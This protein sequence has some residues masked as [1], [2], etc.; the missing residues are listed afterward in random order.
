MKKK[1]CLFFSILFSALAV[2][3][4]DDPVVMHVNGIPVTRSEFEYNYNKNNAEGVIDKKTVEEYAQLFINYK[5]KVQAAMD[6]H[7]DTLTSFQKEFRTYRDQ[8][9]RPMLVP[10]TVMEEECKAYYA[11]ML[12]SLQGKDL[13]RP[14]H[15]FLRLPQRATKA[16]QEAMKARIDSVYTALK[17]GADFAELARKI[18]QDPQSAKQGGLLPWI[19]PNQTLK[20]F[21]DVAYSLEVGSYSTPFLSTVGY[22]IIK[23]EGK[24]A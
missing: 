4:Q 20:E 16:E 5:L 13:I 21:E 22:H 11:R 2:V 12:S 1:N 18:S 9:I 19:G 3:A 6:A 24:R 10:E 23:L 8:Q 17:A 15:I 14:A 7:L